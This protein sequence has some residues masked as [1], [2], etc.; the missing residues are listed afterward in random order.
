MRCIT[1]S[2][3]SHHKNVLCGMECAYERSY[4]IYQKHK[5]NS[6]YSN[7]YKF[8]YNPCTVQV[9]GFIQFFRHAL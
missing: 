3:C 7:V 9:S 8:G 6:R 1:W 4:K 2:A 5:F